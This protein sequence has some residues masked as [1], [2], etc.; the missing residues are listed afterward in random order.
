MGM[1][2]KK[3]VAKQVHLKCPT[4]N[5]YFAKSYMQ[6]HLGKEQ[7][8]FT[9]CSDNCSLQFTMKLAMGSGNV[10]EVAKSIVQN[11]LKIDDEVQVAP[12]YSNLKM[13]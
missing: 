6:T 3:E 8:M 10:N 12:V 7:G 11:V 5:A 13:N 4:C 2:Q 9:A 1:K